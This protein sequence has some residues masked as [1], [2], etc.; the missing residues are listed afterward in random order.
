VEEC[1]F[2]A[3]DCGLEL[4]TQLFHANVD[5]NTQQIEVG[6]MRGMLL[7]TGECVV[8]SVVVGIVIRMCYV[9]LYV[10]LWL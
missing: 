1:G 7:W 5:E 4:M 10:V 3:G 9:V 6:V 8:I 2:D